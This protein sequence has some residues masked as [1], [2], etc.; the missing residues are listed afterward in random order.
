MTKAREIL[1]SLPTEAKFLAVHR[2]CIINNDLVG[3][4][5]SQNLCILVTCIGVGGHP[6]PGC[7]QVLVQASIVNGWMNKSKKK[8]KLVISSL[9][10]D[11]CLQTREP[12]A[13]QEPRYYTACSG[14]D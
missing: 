5:R 3:L 8:N 14:V 11:T 10:T 6:I 4:V 2:K 7:H 9:A 12:D 13:A 1:Q